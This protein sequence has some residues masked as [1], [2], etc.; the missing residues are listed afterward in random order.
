MCVL[1]VYLDPTL[2]LFF[3][4]TQRSVVVL[5]VSNLFVLQLP[6]DNDYW[7]GRYE[8]GTV[9]GFMSCVV[10]SN[11]ESSFSRPC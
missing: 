6:N 1:T 7:T 3:K 4:K 2:L 8:R 5:L 10:G 11:P 9:N